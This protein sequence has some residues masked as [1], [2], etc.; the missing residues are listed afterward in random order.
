MK[1]RNEINESH[2]TTVTLADPG[3]CPLMNIK[4]IIPRL[5][6][7]CCNHL[8]FRHSLC[9]LVY[10]CFSSIELS[11]E[12]VMLEKKLQGAE[13]MSA[14]NASKWNFSFIYVISQNTRYMWPFFIFFIDSSIFFS[15]NLERT[16]YGMYHFSGED[17][18]QNMKPAMMFNLL[19]KPGSFVCDRFCGTSDCLQSIFIGYGTRVK[20][21]N[22]VNN[23]SG[24]PCKLPFYFIW[25]EVNALLRP[26]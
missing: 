22:F 15:L 25:Q 24:I 5:L 26:S 12:N 13:N 2:W 23:Y 8:K 7:F 11:V 21:S 14:I 16:T 17:F 20:I 10:W 1:L 9:S 19:T 3:H 4:R 18:H 6:M